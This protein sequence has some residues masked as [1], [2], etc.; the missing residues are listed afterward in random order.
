MTKPGSSYTLVDPTRYRPDRWRRG[1]GAGLAWPRSARPPGAHRARSNGARSWSPCARPSWWPG[2]PSARRRGGRA[3]L[4]R[5]ERRAGAMGSARRR[6][7]R[8]PGSSGP[9]TNERT[10]RS[11]VLP[12]KREAWRRPPRAPAQGAIGCAR[13]LGERDLWR[14]LLGSAIGERHGS[15][16][17]AR[18]TNVCRGDRAHDGRCGR[19]ARSARDPARQGAERRL[20][21][22]SNPSPRCSQSCTTAYAPSSSRVWP[23]ECALEAACWVDARGSRNRGAITPRTC[24]P[25]GTCGPASRRIDPELGPPIV[26]PAPLLLGPSWEPSGRRRRAGARHRA[27][28]TRSTLRP[29]RWY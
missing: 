1:A 27:R 28:T 17:A 19:V 22:S 14:R 25:G 18:P 3:E 13:A 21:P 10:G 26:T 2:S 15:V 4:L 5:T 23:N 7:F 24:S 16:G 20:P 29:S 8:G 9:W 6:R 12:R 11:I